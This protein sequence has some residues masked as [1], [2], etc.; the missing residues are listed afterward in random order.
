MLDTPRRAQPSARRRHELALGPVGLHLRRPRRHVARARGRPPCASRPTP[1]RACA[2]VWQ[3]VARRPR[4]SPTS[5]TPASSPPRSSAPTTGASRSPSSRELWDHPHRPAVAAR[6]RR[7]VPPHHRPRPRRRAPAGHRRVGRR[8]L[9]H[10]RRHHLGGRQHAASSRRSCRAP[11]P[12][13]GQ[14]VHKVA[15]HP[16]RPDTLFV[17]HHWGVYR[18]D[19]FGEHVARGRRG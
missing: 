8:L 4:R 11:E 5:S 1:V 9:P 14:C 17:Q 7:P 15:Q 19:D 13:F 6:R 12:E 3:L 18:S 16:T 2:R 10:P